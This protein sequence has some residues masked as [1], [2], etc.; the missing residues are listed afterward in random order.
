MNKDIKKIDEKNE[1]QEVI[2]NKKLTV[3]EKRE[4]DYKLMLIDFNKRIQRLRPHMSAV[5]PKHVDS[6]RLAKIAF[7]EYRK[8]PRLQECEP[9]SILM[10]IMIAAEVGLEPGKLGHCYLVPTKGKCELY[11][12]YKGMIE[13][14][15]R[16]NRVMSIRAEEVCEN[17]FFEAQNGTTCKLEHRVNYK[18]ARGEPYAYYAV[19]DLKDGYS[20]F[21]V[22]SKLD[23][24]K[25]RL[26]SPSAKSTFTPWT[27]HYSEMAKKTVIR[28]LFKY[29]PVSVDIQKAV[30][31]D[32]GHDSGIQQ[33]I[34]ESDFFEIDEDTGE[35]LNHDDC[36]SKVNSLVN[37]I[38]G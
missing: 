19:A 26:N 7:A 11:F 35:I 5:L 36:A 14:A 6:Q 20:T 21:C 34:I 37:K 18:E 30:T 33:E 32:E 3:A 8:N 28:R 22:M 23:I 12:G 16:S 9:D 25:I 4:Q 10:S 31:I 13:L 15:M 38:G 29:L 2:M 27:S 24:E 17:D 1:S